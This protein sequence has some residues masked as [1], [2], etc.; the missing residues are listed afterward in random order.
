MLP[1]AKYEVSLELV[2]KCRRSRVLK[3]RNLCFEIRTSKV[4]VSSKKEK[5]YKV[6]NIMLYIYGLGQKRYRIKNFI[7]KYL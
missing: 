4:L 6:M 1:N 2:E 7:N 3:Q 5:F